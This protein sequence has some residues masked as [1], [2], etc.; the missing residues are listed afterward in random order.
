MNSNRKNAK[1]DRDDDSIR[2]FDSIGAQSTL[3]SC[4]CGI[5]RLGRRSILLPKSS[6]LRVFAV[7][8]GTGK[9]NI[10]FS[11]CTA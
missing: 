9:L 6:P 10:A 4:R 7:D 5:D 8:V 11:S 2:K 1:G 3:A